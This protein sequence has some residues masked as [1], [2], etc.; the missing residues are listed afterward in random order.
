MRHHK[1]G[2]EGKL[3]ADAVEDFRQAKVAAGGQRLSQKTS[4]TDWAS[5]RGL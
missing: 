3:V 2:I 1:Q 4:P 5:F